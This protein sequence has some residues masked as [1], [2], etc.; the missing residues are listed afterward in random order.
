MSFLSTPDHGWTRRR[1]LEAASAFG[2]T[3]LAPGRLFAQDT[4][5]RGGVLIVAADGEPRNL[6]PAVVA[7]NGVFYVAS[8]V[9]EPLAEMGEGGALLPR[10]RDEL[11]GERRRRQHHVQA[12]QQRDLA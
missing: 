10:T 5:K 11:V 9:I 1:F 6:N 7:S 2:A 12:P 8:K 4:P 3:S